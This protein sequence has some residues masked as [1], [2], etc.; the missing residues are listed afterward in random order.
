MQLGAKVEPVRVLRGGE[1]PG[2]WALPG[3]A[4]AYARFLAPK[5]HPWRRWPDWQ[6]DLADAEFWTEWSRQ[7]AAWRGETAA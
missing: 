3:I 5:F 4:R 2:T 7:A 6:A 1:S